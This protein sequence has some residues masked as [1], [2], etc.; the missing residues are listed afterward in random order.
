M[1]ILLLAFAGALG[2]ACRFGCGY[3]ASFFFEKGSPWGIAIINIIGCLLFGLISGYFENRQHWSP[4]FK[5]IL[6]TGFVGSFTTFS[7]YLFEIQ[8]L[9]SQKMFFQACFSFIIQNVA[10]FLALILG[11]SAASF[12]SSLK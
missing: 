3:L 1:T 6:L 11:I 9:I 12:L 10:G 7:T 5:T 2:A 4:E 8:T